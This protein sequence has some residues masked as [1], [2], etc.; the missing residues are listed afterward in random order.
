MWENLY[1]K[2]LELQIN[3]V[4]LLIRVLYN[5]LEAILGLQPYFSTLW[6]DKLTEKSKNNKSTPLFFDMIK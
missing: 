3:E 4:N 2:A 6:Q 1:S 5:F